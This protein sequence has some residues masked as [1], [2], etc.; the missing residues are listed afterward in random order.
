MQQ[1]GI[2]GQL[3]SPFKSIYDMKAPTA[4]QQ[5]PCTERGSSY[6][7]K[8]PRRMELAGRATCSALGHL[9]VAAAVRTATGGAVA[10]HCILRLAYGEE[11]CVS[12]WQWVC[13]RCTLPSSGTVG[14][15]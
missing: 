2:T 13:C 10:M 14:C 4:L 15:S 11:G 8:P 3:S 7:H 5:R 12:I 9:R 6:K 1:C